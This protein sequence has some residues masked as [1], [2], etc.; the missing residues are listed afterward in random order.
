[1]KKIEI[2]SNAPKSWKES[3]VYDLLEIYNE[4]K[5]HEGYAYSYKNRKNKTVESV[6]AN[7]PKGSSILDVA[8]AQG[9]FSLTLAELG[10]D[11][12][13]NDLRSELKGY[14]ESKHEFGKISYVS[15][16]VFDIPAEGQFELILA[17]EIIEHVAHP[18]QFLEKLS[19]LVKKG[20]Y[21]LIT[22][23]LGSY[24]LNNLPKFTEFENPEIFESVQFKPNSDGH[25]F[26]LHK[27]EVFFVAERAG[28]DVVEYETYTNPLTNGHLKTSFLLKIVPENI[29]FRIERW[30]QKL[31]WSIKKKIHTG[32]IALLR[33]RK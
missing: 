5:G 28:L 23:P 3:Y 2:K 33:K 24:M 8:A 11:V 18:D 9:N 14:V 31:P 12:T 22:T 16:N 1:M 26:L 17:T 6:L 13:W 20:G 29:V 30:S 10:Y 7:L 21:I 32:S 25:I 27:E 19:R 15:G 4:Y